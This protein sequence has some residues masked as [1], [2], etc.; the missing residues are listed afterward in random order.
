MLIEGIMMIK[1]KEY[2][3]IYNNSLMPPLGML[4]IYA[5]KPHSKENR[6][7]RNYHITY[8]LSG[9]AKLE[10]NNKS[11]LINKSET[12]IIP[13]DFEYNITTETGYEQFDIILSI[14]NK[15]R[16]TV[17]K[18]FVELTQ[19][20]IITTKPI[21]FENTFE[22]LKKLFTLPTEI[23]CY[24]LNIKAE[25]ILL[26]ILEQ[27]HPIETSAFKRKIAEITALN[28]NNLTLG[29]LCEL[30]GYSPTHFERLMLKHFGCSGVEYFNKMKLE[31]I[32]NLLKTTDLTL[33]EIA[34]KLE[35][36]D[37]SH[38]NTFFK[39][40]MGITPAK[41]RKVI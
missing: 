2:Y 24:S 20:G 4:S 23:N 6:C 9:S 32:C 3:A 35:F 1:E 33:K 21:K 15:Q 10:F 31:R 38:L 5:K 27:I 18:H 7:H 26:N 36:Y 12:V 11:V 13:P 29:A 25:S 34:E 22:D 37:T 17:W 28:K 30:S 14:W 40:R 39:K 16:Q 19:N 41:Y 8:I